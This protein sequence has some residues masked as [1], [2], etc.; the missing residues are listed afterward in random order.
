[1]ILD[2][3]EFFSNAQS[4]AA[5][6]GDVASTDI[7]DTGAAADAGIGEELYLQI[8]TIAAVTSGGA[9]TVQFVLQTDDNSAF[10]SP[11]EFLL[12]APV[13][14]AALTANTRQYLGRLPVGLERYLRV[15]YR[16]A[17]AT[18]TAGTATAF[19]VKNPQVA[20]SLPT[21]VPGVK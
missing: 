8:N 7:Y 6:A 13:A 20:P 1:M 5:A 10:S 17:T 14:L 12:T 3:M 16:I 21:T 4:I 19:L 9:A 11:K 2:S 18:T 15:V